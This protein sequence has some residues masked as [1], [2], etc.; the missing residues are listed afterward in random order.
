LRE[1]NHVRCC[2]CAANYTDIDGDL[3]FQI[4]VRNPV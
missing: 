2:F 1:Y 3:Y 4:V